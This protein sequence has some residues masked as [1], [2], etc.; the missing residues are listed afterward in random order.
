MFLWFCKGRKTIKNRSRRALE[1]NFFT[2]LCWTPFFFNFWLNFYRFLVD[3]GPILASKCFPFSW[4]QRCR[5]VLGHL[6]SISK[7]RYLNIPFAIRFLTDFEW[8]LDQFLTN[9][10]SPKHKKSTTTLKFFNVTSKFDFGDTYEANS[11]FLW[12]GKGFGIQL[13]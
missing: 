12:F 6:F 10:R 11:M 8:I 4:A 3:F 9:F 7:R 13:F 5:T 1:L 2:S